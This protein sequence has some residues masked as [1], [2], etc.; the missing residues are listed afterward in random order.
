MFSEAALKIYAMQRE[1]LIKSNAHFWRTFSLENVMEFEVDPRDQKELHKSDIRLLCAFDEDFFVP[2]LPLRASERPYLF[3]YR[4]DASLL[5]N[6]KKNIAVVG[7]LNP[8]EDVKERE[9]EIVKQLVQKGFVIV[10]GLAR[11]C[12]TVAHEECLRCGGKP[13]AFLPTPLNKIYP[14][15]NVTLAKWIVESGGLIVTE[16]ISEPKTR[17]EGIGRFLARDRL[18]AMFSS[19]VILTASYLQGEGDSGSRHALE[20]AKAYGRERYVMYRGTDAENSQFGLNRRLLAEGATVL[21]PKILEQ[22]IE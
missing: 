19:R 12:D 10:S 14:K 21:S 3:A 17:Q 16:Y 11:G 2:D 18:Q 8:D 1:G 20:K 7:V 9:K 13:I 6:I 5:K 15:E 22:F 4:G